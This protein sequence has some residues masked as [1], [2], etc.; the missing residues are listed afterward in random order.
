MVYCVSDLLWKTDMGKHV[1]VI[2]IK[3]LKLVY[4]KC[5]LFEISLVLLNIQTSELHKSWIKKSLYFD[6]I[7]YQS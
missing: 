2:G 1:D 7:R 5:Y 4:R 6:T 3:K